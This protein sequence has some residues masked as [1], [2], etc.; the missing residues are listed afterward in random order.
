MRFE[1]RL[2]VI[3]GADLIPMIDV[4]FQ[5]VIFFM[6][7]STFIQTPGIALQMPES[8]SAEPVVM[9]RLVVTIL[10]DETVY[11]NDM[12]YRLGEFDGALKA[13][14]KDVKEELSSVVIEGDM[15]VSYDLMIR[16]LDILRHN[17]FSGVNL[18]LREAN[19]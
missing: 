15:K 11:L 6:L 16:V 14:P 4:V 18:R 13:L 17:G 10:P 2:K 12:A 5:L 3:S 7:S 8:T 9:T 19:E 1:R